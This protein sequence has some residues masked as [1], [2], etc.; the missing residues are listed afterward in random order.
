MIPSGRAANPHPRLVKY[1][2]RMRHACRA[3]LGLWL[4][5]VAAVPARADDRIYH[6]PIGD[7]ERRTR[8]VPVVLDT[9]VASA[10][11][12][13]LSPEELA[14]Q[15]EPVR[16]LLI[17]ETHTSMEAHRVQLQVLRALHR[18]G[19]RVIVGLEMYPY[20]KQDALDG[21]REGR[22]TED[23]FLERADWHEQWGYHWGYYREIFVFVREARLPLLALNAPREVVTAV[24]KTG[25]DELPADVRAHLPPS[26][27]LHS[28]DHL[29][30]FKASFD[31]DDT[32]HGGM[33]DD[34]WRAMLSAQ[35]TW[36]AAMAWHALQAIEPADDPRAIVVVLAGSGHVA[37]GV[38]IERQARRWFD[39][40]IASVIPVAVADEDGPTPT[41]R[42]SYAD[43]VWGIAREPAPMYPSLGVSTR[44][45]AA[46]HREII[47]VEDDSPAAAA[48]LAVGDAIVAFQGESIDSRGA[49]SRAIAGCRWGDV[50][51]L[52][53]A[54]DGAERT[55]RVPLRRSR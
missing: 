18:A 26:I 3:A 37:Y 42:A 31:A 13:R 32:V 34:A 54:R 17:G 51:E 55:V 23:E 20:T 49:L 21:W 29:T 48:G 6:L 35:A 14:T 4:V 15:L 52:T 11:G 33:T 25:L 24:R 28:D 50:V 41:V 40:P 9:V 45:A 36:D 12:D 30:F 2:L 38:G 22:W 16:L 1:D 10:T 43:F 44:A 39:G 19:R 8:E 53:I 47:A 7:A 5:V 46:G 27:D